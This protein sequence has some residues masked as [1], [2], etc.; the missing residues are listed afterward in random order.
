MQKRN[1]S[2]V[3]N[4]TFKIN[5]SLIVHSIILCSAVPLLVLLHF[6]IPVIWMS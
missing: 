4:L 1:H 2:L 6:A 5:F 3:L